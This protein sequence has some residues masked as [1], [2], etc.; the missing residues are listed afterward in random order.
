MTQKITRK[1]A[2]ESSDHKDVMNYYST[3]SRDETGAP[4]RWKMNS[5]HEEVV[6]GRGSP[7][8]AKIARSR[9]NS[10]DSSS[11]R[12]KTDSENSQ[13]KLS[14]S[15]KKGPVKK[16]Q[17]S[18][19]SVES[20]GTGK[21][22]SIDDIA[23]T[24]KNLINEK[25]KTEKSNDSLAQESK[26]K[27][28]G[29]AKSESFMHIKEL[30]KQSVKHV[31]TKNKKV[32]KAETVVKKKRGRPKSLDFMNSESMETVANGEDDYFKSPHP[33]T[34]C[35]ILV[36][37]KKGRPKETPPTLEPEPSVSPNAPSN[38]D[39]ISGDETQN[40]KQEYKRKAGPGR[41]AKKRKISSEVTQMSDLTSEITLK[42]EIDRKPK[43]VKSV[44]RKLADKTQMIGKRKPVLPLKAKTMIFKSKN[45]L[46]VKKSEKNQA[47]EGQI[48]RKGGRPP[49]SKNKPKPVAVLI[50]E[51]KLRRS[52]TDS[53]TNLETR[54]T[55]EPSTNEVE[56]INEDHVSDYTISGISE[57]S[58]IPVNDVSAIESKYKIVIKEKLSSKNIK[59][60]DPLRKG[61][62]SKGKVN[63]KSKALKTEKSVPVVKRKKILAAYAKKHTD[64]SIAS[65]PGNDLRR[66]LYNK[67]KT[68]V[69]INEKGSTKNVAEKKVDEK[70]E[71]NIAL[72]E[73]QK[74]SPHVAD[75]RDDETSTS[76]IQLSKS[77]SEVQNLSAMVE[78][79]R[80]TKTEKDQ[81]TELVRKKGRPKKSIIDV[82]ESGKASD[83]ES[84][85]SEISSFSSVSNNSI[86]KHSQDTNSAIKSEEMAVTELTKVKKKPGRKRK[87]ILND[88]LI[89]RKSDLEAKEHKLVPKSGIIYDFEAD[90]ATNNDMKT[91]IEIIKKR[92]SIPKIL[93]P[94]GTSKTNIKT[95]FKSTIEQ[96]VRPQ[97][98]EDVLKH[99]N[100]V[101][102]A[103]DI[104]SEVLKPELS[105]L[106]RKKEFY[107]SA[108]VNAQ[109][110][111]KLD[112]EVKDELKVSGKDAEIKSD[113]DV[114]NCYSEVKL[115]VPLYS[116]KTSDD[117]V[118]DKDSISVDYDKNKI[119]FE[120]NETEIN[121]DEKK[122]SLNQV[123]NY[124]VI[125]SVKIDN[126]EKSHVSC[127]NENDKK[128]GL[129]LAQEATC[130]IEDKIY[131]TND[132]DMVTNKI[133][134]CSSAMN[135]LMNNDKLHAE[136]K[137]KDILLA[138][139]QPNTSQN[140]EENVENE[141]IDSEK[142]N[143]EFD[144]KSIM[145]RA[146]AISFEVTEKKRLLKEKIL[147]GREFN[148][149]FI[150]KA[151]DV[152]DEVDEG[153]MVLPDND[154]DT[155][156]GSSYSNKTEELNVEI[157][158]EEKFLSDD[159]TDE[160]TFF[161]DESTESADEIVEEIIKSMIDQVC[162]QV[163]IYSPP[164]SIKTDNLK[165][166]S[167]VTSLSYSADEKNI[168]EY[169]GNIPDS[170]QSMKTF[171][172]GKGDSQN[173][174]FKVRKPITKTEPVK[175]RKRVR[176]RE[177]KSTKEIET[178]VVRKIGLRQK[179]SRS[180]LDNIALRQSIEENEYIKEQ[181]KKTK[182]GPKPKLKQ[183][184]TLEPEEVLATSKL[185][186]QSNSITEN[187]DVSENTETSV[188][189]EEIS[190]VPAVTIEDLRKECKPC[191]VILK[192]FLKQLQMK[193]TMDSLDVSQEASQ[194]REEEETEKNP[195]TSED[196]VKTTEKEK[197]DSCAA[198]ELDQEAVSEVN[199]IEERNGSKKDPELISC[200]N[201]EVE[202][203]SK[204]KK[205]P[206]KDKLISL[207]TEEEKSVS[208]D[209]I[210][211]EQNRKPITESMNKELD[212][213]RRGKRTVKGL[214]NASGLNLP[215][216]SLRPREVSPKAVSEINKEDTTK[217]KLRD[218]TV[219]EISDIA[220]RKHKLVSVETSEQTARKT[221]P[222][223]KIK[224]QGGLT[225]KTKVY[226]VE[227]AVNA[228][229]SSVDSALDKKPKKKF[230]SKSK[231][232]SESEKS[233]K[234][235][236]HH[237][238]A[239]KVTKSPDKSQESDSVKHS[240]KKI[241]ETQ[242]TET[243]KVHDAYEANFLAFIQQQE[244]EDSVNMANWRNPIVSKASHQLV[245]GKAC[246]SGDDG[247]LTV[248]ACALAET[249][250]S[251]I[252][253]DKFVTLSK[254]SVPST[255]ENN[256]QNGQ[257][258]Q[259]KTSVCDESV[260]EKSDLEH[261]QQTEKAVSNLASKVPT[262]KQFFC[263]HCEFLCETQ[264]EIMEHI[265]SLHKDQLLYSCTIC[266][267]VTFKT[268]PAILAHFA[269]YHQGMKDS[270]ICLPDYYEKQIDPKPVK[271]PTDQPDNIFDRMSNLF[272][273]QSSKAEASKTVTNSQ[274]ES[275]GPSKTAAEADSTTK[276]DEGEDQLSS[277]AISVDEDSDE[278]MTSAE[279][280]D[281]KAVE[282][283]ATPVEER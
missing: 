105:K 2:S 168:R 99:L 198:I 144:S 140:S 174:T 114:S 95:A 79:K 258:E 36:K 240:E 230:K 64:S 280:Q 110:S 282:E 34:P 262:N 209:T 255:T 214:R 84:T 279:V 237:H 207:D 12:K 273:I 7:A 124:S 192:D 98:N 206:Q 173:V 269:T 134:E 39:T 171:N 191:S 91:T 180:P 212:Q 118:S 264:N 25:R 181:M 138:S 77:T 169:L 54:Y 175:W 154:I 221:V 172:V 9:S 89:D 116:G 162:K 16:T 235:K 106:E 72:S 59:T 48:K 146:K 131:L 257:I 69:N 203:M 271:S 261:F 251:S 184:P 57:T 265:K 165:D 53:E 238:H 256:V 177:K 58:S 200:E 158:K 187:L 247:T 232:D 145:D 236:S 113:I 239:K 104:K 260:T 196:N 186:E 229:P 219:S 220:M 4:V 31:V 35:N 176:K 143:F 49:G 272:D 103:K 107:I 148:K 242:K 40:E 281:Q 129:L 44:N 164:D 126:K 19:N 136:V 204:D 82:K 46:N 133:E 38:A 30:Q 274:A 61:L 142:I 41:P 47:I 278:E 43:K 45:N 50:K 109:D 5:M 218:Q 201:K 243:L 73:L 205:S 66:I 276:L 71:D 23:T 37:P 14:S 10:R 83:N 266:H 283:E 195:L 27:K 8:L 130:D 252:G 100:K 137:E 241:V 223:L 150:Y 123:V 270:Y 120:K 51:S 202:S 183:S 70:E 88:E 193:N 81:N 267:K 156:K 24:N 159:G 217:D 55:L 119:N 199:Q 68:K 15:G 93:K 87:Q 115:S 18:V 157:D 227:T 253:S 225:S 26:V 1:L 170:V 33:L 213:K 97:M 74:Q 52:S 208:K 228:N 96:T 182:R 56:S 28:K 268:K 132:K 197:S 151:V 211:V 216:R 127:N 135:I 248:S 215:R 210:N 189:L 263:N 167:I 224:L 179:I 231:S 112:G 166:N 222:P 6:P 90:D 128:E 147:K 65:L 226:T 194:V 245:G 121:K 125:Q 63:P 178:P 122:C 102:N 250:T 92:K 244:K 3:I 111:K 86:R 254:S 11:E 163:S 190:P 62:V 185:L 108:N 78:S 152:N 249:K 141:Q 22:S 13:S 67:L 76:D 139:P 188:C 94:D 259:S 29:R 21:D 60:K 17:D 117:Q 234:R 246:K 85:C 161:E 153:E 277:K 233:E 275:V 149:S 32:D 20:E 42:T 155:E 80:Y 75:D 160:I 101:K